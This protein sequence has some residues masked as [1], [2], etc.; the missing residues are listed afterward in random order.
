MSRKILVIQTA[1]IGDVILATALLEQIHAEEPQTQL[2]VLVRD[3][4]QSLL[5][6]HPFVHDVWIWNKRKGKYLGLFH[7]LKRIR[8]AKFDVV[9]N[10]QRFASTGL[11]T[12]FSK[13]REKVGFD[14]NP[15]SRW[16]TRRVKHQISA[17]GNHPI[18]HEVDRISS[19][20]QGS[21]YAQPRPK[22]YPSQRDAEAIEAFTTSSFI[23]I[24]PGSVWFTKQVPMS[25][26]KEL[27]AATQQKI[28]LLGAP[29]DVALCQ[30]LAD[31]HGHVEVL[32]GRLTLL[33]SAALM[34]RATMNYVNDSAPLHLC[35]AMNAPVV[36]VFCST[37]PAF[38]FGPLSDI[39]FVVE[40]EPSPSCRPCG[41]HGKSA[42]PKGHFQC[43]QVKLAQRSSSNP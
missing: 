14:K 9:Y 21:T 30:S 26:W 4:N 37:I 23:T 41:L 7:L 32:A 19:L 43:G 35:S 10:L 20:V 15:F 17:P 31:G 16:F 38:G 40:A 39:S 3:G 29:T 5:E 25:V 11:L 42:C 8:A 12:A 27:I 1:F 2:T 13:A 24:S 33:Q 18:I 34:Q 6:N 36:A 22:L 28:F